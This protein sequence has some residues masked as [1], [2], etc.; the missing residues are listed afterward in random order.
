[1]TLNAGDKVIFSSRTIPGNEREVGRIINNLI[2]LGIDVVTDRNALVHASGHPRRG[3]VS[4]LYAWTAAADRHS[5]PWRGFASCR[6]C[7]LREK[8][9]VPH[10]VRARN[11]DIVA[12]A[13]GAPGIVGQVQNGRL[14]KDGKILVA[15]DRRGAADSP[16]AGGVGNHHH[17]PC[18]DGEGRP[19]RRARRHDR[20]H[21]GA[22]ARWRRDGRDRR[23]RAVPDLR[24]IAAAKAARRRP[25]FRRRSKKPCATRSRRPGAS[26]P[27]CTCSLSKC[28]PVGRNCAFKSRSVLDLADPRMRPALRDARRRFARVLTDFSDLFRRLRSTRMDQNIAGVTR[29]CS[30]FL[31][32]NRNISMIITAAASASCA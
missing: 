18:G 4:Q 2:R 1:M 16:E 22:D 25:R 32:H 17:R 13:P 20:G 28:E 15:R 7:G 27:P 3:E 29:N 21:P 10:V 6:T 24:P 5:R 14:L 26:V 30:C 31:R 8:Q 11:G 12:L 23:R 19:R 9:G